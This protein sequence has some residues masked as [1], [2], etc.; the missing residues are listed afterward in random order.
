LAL[1]AFLLALAIPTSAAAFPETSPELSTRWCETG[2][3]AGQ[4]K[5]PRGIAADPRNGHVFVVDQQNFRIAESNALGEFISAWG[6]DVVQSGPGNAGTGLETCEPDSG[7][8]CKV[9]TVGGG[10]GQLSELAM[11]AAVDSAGDVYVTDRGFLGNPSVRVQKYSPNGQFLLMFG[12][13]V[14]KTKVE[15]GGAS[16]AEE[17]LCPFD[18]GDQCQ[19]GAIGTGAGQFGKWEVGDFITVDEKGT[20]TDADDVVY[21]GDAG[22]IQKFDTD[23]IYQGEIAVSGTVQSLDV[24]P[25]GDL[26]RGGGGSI[27]KLSP[28]GEL[29]GEFKLQFGP[30]SAVTVDATSHVYA[31]GRTCS[32]CAGSP[33]ATDPITEFG[34]EGKV[35]DK[36][37]IDEFSDSTGIE[38]N[39]CAESEAPGNLYASNLSET[40]AFIRA[41]G[42]NPIGCFKARTGPAKDVKETSVTLTGTVIPSGLE[43]SECFFEWGTT[44]AYGQKAECEPKASEIVGSEPVAVQATLSGLPKGTVHHFRLVAKVGPELETGADKSFKTLGPPVISEERTVSVAYTEAALKALVNPEGFASS[45]RFQYTTQA[46]FE[47]EG[48]AGA[49]STS[50]IALGKDGDRKEHAVA[51]NL[52]GLE[53][54][55]AYRWRVLAA[56]SS[57]AREGAAQAL[58]TYRAPGADPEA[59]PNQAFRGGSSAKLPDCRAYEMVSPVD[60]NG[61]DIASALSGNANPGGFVQAAPDG[62]SIAYTALFASFAGQQ[63]SYRFNQY[64]AGRGTGSWASEGINPPVPGH[65]CCSGIIVGYF[66]EFEA[67]SADLC[68]AW[69]LDYQEPAL[70]PEGQDGLPNILRRDNCEPGT[71]ELETLTDAPLPQGT[72]DNYVDVNSVQGA[73]SDGGHALFVSKAPLLQDCRT[74]TNAKA[75]SYRWLRD[76]APIEGATAPVYEPVEA[77]R[78][79]AL[80]CQVFAINDNAGSTQVS[81]P[82][83]VIPPGPGAE[84]APPAAPAAIPSPT[85]NATLTVGGP[86]GQTLT[87]DSEGAGWGGSPSFSYRW[88]RNGVAIAGAVASTY[89]TSAADLATRAVFQCA[90]TGAN[91]DGAVVEASA[92]RATSPAPS[93]PAAP[94]VDASGGGGELARV[95][96]RF[97][98]ENHLAS[99]LPNGRPADTDAGLGSGSNRDGAVSEDGS[100]VYWSSSSKIYLR[101]HPKQ[102]IVANE[103]SDNATVACTLPVSGAGAFFW[104]ASADGSRVLYDQETLLGPRKLVVFDLAKQEAGEVS[105]RDVTADVSGVVGA[106]DDLSRVYFVSRAVLA[107]GAVAGEPNLY[108]DEEGET[109][110]VATLAEDDLGAGALVAAYALDS[111]APYERATRVSADGSR[112]VFESQASLTGFD[113]ADAE[114]GRPSVEVYIYD[115]TADEL[116]C[117][118]CNPSG[119][120]PSGGREMLSPYG[121]PY[122]VVGASTGVTAAAW[123]PTWEHPLHASNVLSA[124]GDRIFFNANDALLPADTNGAQDVYE[125]EAPGIGGCEEEGA[126]F[127]AQNGGCLYLISS[128]QS[129]EESEFWE[130]SPDGD[131]VFFTTSASLVP[132]DP[133]SID[134]YD[135]RVGGGFEYP[136][137]QAQCEGEACQ[138]PPEAPNDPTPASSSFEG[139]G[140]VAKEAPKPAPRCAKGKVRKH[141]RC[142]AKH[143]K[144]HRRAKHGQRAAR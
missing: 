12:G 4:C 40:N 60:K 6:W 61:G 88:Y 78:G 35:L 135:A 57:G 30:S 86:G 73:S 20:A 8:V 33:I 104:A 106:S 79:T 1:A 22:R 71:G 24:G 139:A 120:R 82:A 3:G 76:G 126:N 128:G 29:L 21:V 84:I 138:S 98:G 140:N 19:K 31:F 114:S 121:S 41:Y 127:F 108:L 32:Q 81:N 47:T 75:I 17:N 100:R 91:A 122:E 59:C 89:V 45:Y 43:V 14:N 116:S 7:D 99:V 118:S 58:F 125:W 55:T 39:L 102:G 66:R 131:N 144:R 44:K 68:S 2:A 5:I 65:N 28:S 42:T 124:D 46:D 11:G 87:C 23:G 103:C 109:S 38:A 133:G 85:T 101:L 113:N 25:D 80:Q 52:S 132:P 27:Q 77:D 62:N 95:Y 69:V 15:A 54:G 67:L 130:A 93:G 96:D 143:H 50:E 70:Q 112:I 53:P 83:S 36:F 26:Y 123:I 92:N 64:L 34:P 117:V 63:S 9:G 107:T 13:E 142:V 129:P 74:A 51:V 48:F 49:Q 90:V 119:A 10:T 137:P 18:P 115:A 105:R 97:G 37:G 111:G 136:E 56:N 110:L 141:G 134:L 16:E 94:T 72:A